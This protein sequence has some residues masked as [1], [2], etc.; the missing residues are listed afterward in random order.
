[1]LG[2]GLSKK[3]E[4]ECKEKVAAA[5]ASAGSGLYEDAEFP[6]SDAKE[7]LYPEFSAPQLLLKNAHKFPGMT[8]TVSLAPRFSAPRLP[9]A[10]GKA[11]WAYLLTSWT[12]GQCA[13]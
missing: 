4:N 5:S 2:Q 6:A 10:D 11:I 12:E 1:M 13:T 3:L 7:A 8:L 9:Y